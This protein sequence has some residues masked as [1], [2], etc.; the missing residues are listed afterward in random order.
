VCPAPLA[1][2]C[3][4]RKTATFPL[5]FTSETIPAE[6]LIIADTVTAVLLTQ[7]VNATERWEFTIAIIPADDIP[8]SAHSQQFLR[9][10]KANA[11]FIPDITS[12][13]LK[14]AVNIS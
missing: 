11:D 4:I 13:R 7:K 8:S 5:R 9:K 3:Y 6:R 12:H 14:P 2:Y 1:L 10:G